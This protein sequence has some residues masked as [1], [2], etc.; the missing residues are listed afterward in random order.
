M[1]RVTSPGKPLLLLRISSPFSF[2]PPK[3]IQLPSSPYFSCFSSCP[4]LL[5]YT[6]SR[7]S[8][9]TSEYYSSCDPSKCYMGIA[10]SS[11]SFA[12]ETEQQTEWLYLFIPS[13]SPFIM[14]RRLRH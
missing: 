14:P 5:H 11:S 4:S 3:Y 6:H 10:W 12:T 7:S 13:S 2:I 1:H 9:S 8:S